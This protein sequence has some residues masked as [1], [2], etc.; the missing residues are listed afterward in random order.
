MN[1]DLI[2]KV[3]R[4]VASKADDAREAAGAMGS[5]SDGGASTIAMQL[6]YYG[7]GQRGEIP[8][9]WQDAAKQAEHE[10]DPDY[11]KYQE[12]KKKFG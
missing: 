9:A 2:N 1:N 7:Y 12:L 8:P 4:I 11:A 6:E 3:K 10:A 5:Y